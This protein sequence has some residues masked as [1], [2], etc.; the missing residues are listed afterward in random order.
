MITHF[1]NYD[2]GVLY[3]RNNYENITRVYWRTFLTLKKL[4]T[5]SYTFISGNCY[6]LIRYPVD[7]LLYENYNLSE[8]LEQRKVLDTYDNKTTDCGVVTVHP[9][10]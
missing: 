1:L 7:T 2:S 6:L 10:W 4:I 3:K 5:S 9:S 8:N